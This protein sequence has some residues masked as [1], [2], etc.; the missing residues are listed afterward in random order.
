MLKS[1]EW[2]KNAEKLVTKQE[3]QAR[4][5]FPYG[6]RSKKIQNDLENDWPPL[7]TTITNQ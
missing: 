5:N 1:K 4:S 6:N 7:T 2:L 3:I